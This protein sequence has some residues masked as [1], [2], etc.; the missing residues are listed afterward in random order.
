MQLRW[1]KKLKK[2]EEIYAEIASNIFGCLLRKELTK[3][4]FENMPIE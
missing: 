4:N 2:S 3:G 1:F